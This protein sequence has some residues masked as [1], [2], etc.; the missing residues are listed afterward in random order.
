MVLAALQLRAQSQEGDPLIATLSPHGGSDVLSGGGSIVLPGGCVVLT[1][2][3]GVDE[4]QRL[5]R[6]GSVLWDWL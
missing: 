4:E 2:G 6:L 1:D 3:S 5:L